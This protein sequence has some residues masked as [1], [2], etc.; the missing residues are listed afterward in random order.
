MPAT[1]TR[2]TRIRLANER[3]IILDEQDKT[4]AQAIAARD[5]WLATQEL[6]Q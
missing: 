2:E 1:Y 3:G 6:I 4:E 5:R